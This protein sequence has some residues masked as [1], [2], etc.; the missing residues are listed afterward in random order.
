M[1][2]GANLRLHPTEIRAALR[3]IKSLTHWFDGSRSASLNKGR[4]IS[5]ALW[6]ALSRSSRQ[7][8]EGVLDAVVHNVHCFE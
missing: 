5:K 1:A 2:K 8:H 4:A 7:A 3:T 6:F